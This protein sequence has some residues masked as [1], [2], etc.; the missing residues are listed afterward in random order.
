MPES[1]KDIRDIQHRLGL[2]DPAALRQL[3]GIFSDRLFQFAH[4]LLKSREMAEE[5]VEDVFIQV[6]KKSRRI[7]EIENL[8]FY[9]YTCT[10]NFCYNYYRK[11]YRSRLLNI[12]EVELPYYK[13][14]AT[15]EELMIVNEMLQQFHK[16]LN[17]LPPKCRLIFKLVKEEGLKYKE[18]AELLGLSV[19][20]VEAQ[21][22]IAFK[23]LTQSTPFLISGSAPAPKN[24]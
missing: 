15:A 21:M 12:D 9:L 6:W 1:A 8:S 19:K 10:R 16:A 7:S 23:R 3:Y 14:E 17:A 20:T 22:G 11:Y 18:V 2:N 4:A 5:V 24:H 13:I